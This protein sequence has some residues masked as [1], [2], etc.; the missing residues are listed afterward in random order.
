MNR[1]PTPSQA[2]REHFSLVQSHHHGNQ[3]QADAGAGDSRRIAAAKIAL[4][5]A[6]AIARGNSDTVV[7]NLDHLDNGAKLEPEAG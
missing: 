3:V 4:E 6:A 2:F 5:Q 7:A 1:E